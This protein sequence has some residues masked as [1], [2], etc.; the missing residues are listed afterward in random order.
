MNCRTVSPLFHST[1]EC[2]RE[3]GLKV[4][5]TAYVVRSLIVHGA[6]R[7]AIDR[8][9]QKASFDEL[10]NLVTD[11]EE[12]LRRVIFWLSTLDV[13]DRPYL[14]PRGWELLLW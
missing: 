9:L 1:V 3:I 11:I 4:M 12:K 5:R 13:E 10:T 7:E 2:D 6:S 14:K 8:A